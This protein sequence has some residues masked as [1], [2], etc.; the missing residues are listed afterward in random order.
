LPSKNCLRTPIN[1][2]PTLRTRR[3]III[4]VYIFS[5]FSPRRFSMRAMGKTGDG[6]SRKVTP[7]SPSYMSNDQFGK[8]P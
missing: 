1:R 7:P 4:T 8:A 6:K 2:N 5:Y 3:D